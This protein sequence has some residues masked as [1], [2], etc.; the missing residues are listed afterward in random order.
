[1]AKAPFDISTQLPDALTRSLYAGVGVTDRVVEIVREAVAD[2]QKRVH[3]AQQDIQKTVGALDYQP[4]A[5]REQATRAVSASVDTLGKDAEA[6]RRA[7]EHSLGGLQSEAKNVP[8]RLQQLVEG[9]VATAGDTYDELVRRGETVVGRIRRQPPTQETT[10]S[11]R[12]TVA[13]ARTTRT[14]GTSAAKDSA[15]TV[16]KTARKSPA[17]SSAK[18]TGTSAKKTATGAAKATTDAAAKLGDGQVR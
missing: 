10:A 13:K 18:A 8:V 12:T 9:Q 15:S 7:L 2:V 1:M 11:A 17:S 16:K 14:Q 6:R 4:H 3:A 5:L